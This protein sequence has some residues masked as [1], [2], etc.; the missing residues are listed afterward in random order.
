MTTAVAKIVDSE[1][2]VTIVETELK[3]NLKGE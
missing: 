1:G 2:N 3:P